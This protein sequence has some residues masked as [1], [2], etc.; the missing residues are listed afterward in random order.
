[1]NIPTKEGFFWGRW[2]LADD[3]TGPRSEE[4][5]N[6]EWEVM[7]VVYNSVEKDELMAMVPGVEEWQSLDC[8]YWGK[9]REVKYEG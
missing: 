4:A 9:L 5:P 8:F 3:N 2:Q 1:M 7:H 6:R